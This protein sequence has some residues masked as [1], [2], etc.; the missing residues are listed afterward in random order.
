MVMHS[1]QFS[2]ISQSTADILPLPSFL[3][4]DDGHLGLLLPVTIFTTT[5]SPTCLSELHSKFH[6]N[7]TIRGGVMTS[8]R[9]PRW[10]PSAIL[11]FLEGNCRPL[12]TRNWWSEL[13]RQIS[14]RSSVYLGDIV[15][16][17][18]DVLAWDCLFCG[19]FR[20]ACAELRVN[21]LTTYFYL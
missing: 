9:F 12:T 16:L 17:Y 5:L 20:R 8:Q 21:L 7:Q 3:E 4:T 1:S 19:Y 11:N 14:T 10:R 6:S 2:D 15:F 18:C 13:N